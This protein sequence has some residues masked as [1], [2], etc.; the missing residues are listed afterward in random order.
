M[1]FLQIKLFL[2]HTLQGRQ[3]Q[4]GLESTIEVLRPLRKALQAKH[5]VRQWPRLFSPARRC[6]SVKLAATPDRLR[7]RA[8]H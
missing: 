6:V 3:K 1:F 7:L 5:P 8:E 2:P 4:G